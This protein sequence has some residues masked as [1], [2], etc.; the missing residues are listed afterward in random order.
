MIKLIIIIKLDRAVVTLCASRG[1]PIN[2][3]V[4]RQYKTGTLS[5]AFTTVN[6]SRQPTGPQLMSSRSKCWIG[7]Q[8]FSIHRRKFV[9]KKKQKNMAAENSSALLIFRAGAS[10]ENSLFQKVCSLKIVFLFLLLN[11]MTILNT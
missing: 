9:V 2:T 4:S 3:S 11:V 8:T 6:V 10:F 5:I 7:E 1:L